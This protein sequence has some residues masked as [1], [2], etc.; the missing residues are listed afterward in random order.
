MRSVSRFAL[1]P[2]TAEAMF[3]LVNDIESYPDF[4]PWCTATELRSRDDCEVVATLTVGYRSLHTTFTTRNLFQ[5]PEWMTMHL[6][7]G[8]F[9]SLEGRWEFEQLGND[10]CEVTLRM[11]FD[12]SSS[13]KDMLF[14]AVFETICNEMIDAFIKRAHELYGSGENE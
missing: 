6:R 13:V 4:L 12:F 3:S 8:P 9:S 11:E 14:G 1:V 2:F 7:E 10:G 5:A